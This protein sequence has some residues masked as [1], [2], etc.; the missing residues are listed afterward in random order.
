[1]AASHYSVIPV[2]AVASATFTMV[3]VMA[4]LTPGPSSRLGCTFSVKAVPG[5]AVF[6]PLASQS[7]LALWCANPRI[8]SYA[9]T[10]TG[11]PTFYTLSGLALII[12]MTVFIPF[13][14]SIL[15]C[16]SLSATVGLGAV[17]RGAVFLPGA[18]CS[19]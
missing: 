3:I 4:V 17:A 19:V 15:G 18:W 9:I 13:P 7:I 1:M 8:M 2:R 10:R 16:A 12:M 5:L 6:V 11:M 14:S